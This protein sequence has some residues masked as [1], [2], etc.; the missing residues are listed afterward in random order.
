M[1]EHMFPSIIPE[2]GKLSPLADQLTVAAVAQMML[3]ER[4]KAL[5]TDVCDDTID[6]SFPTKHVVIHIG[7]GERETTSICV[8][9]ELI[10]DHHPKVGWSMSYAV[11][12]PPGGDPNDYEWGS[13]EFKLENVKT[14]LTYLSALMVEDLTGFLD[15]TWLKKEDV[16][17][18]WLM[19]VI[20]ERLFGIIKP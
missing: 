12:I 3:K 2:L 6:V 5:T 20:R 17:H 1:I 8:A 10:F 19:D 11:E 9:N 15:P 16:P 13:T 7:F 18:E 4:Y 14:G